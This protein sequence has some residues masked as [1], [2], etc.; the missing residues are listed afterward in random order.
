PRQNGPPQSRGRAPFFG[1]LADA[2][3]T[4][5]YDPGRSRMGTTL[6]AQDRS[7]ATT[8]DVDGTTVGYLLA[9]QP[10]A[11]AT[12]QPDQAFLDQLRRNLVVA[13]IVAGGAGI[14]LG[15]LI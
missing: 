6:N 13:A 11:P 14:V 3:G 12:T 4:V 15:L 10:G 5:V 2:S 7:N 9:I 8:I 1:V